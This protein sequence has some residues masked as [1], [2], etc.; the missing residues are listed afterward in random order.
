VSV[1]TIWVLTGFLVMEAIERIRKPQ[2]IDAKI[3]SFTKQKLNRLSC[4]RFVLKS[5]E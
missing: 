5:M 3:V 1:L 4:Q 2:V